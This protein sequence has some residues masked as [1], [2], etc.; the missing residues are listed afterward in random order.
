MLN[1]LIV[2]PDP[3]IALDLTEAVRAADSRASVETVE[4][5]GDCSALYGSGRRYTHGFVRTLSTHEREAAQGCI[6]LLA[7]A[8]AEVVL[9]GAELPERRVASAGSVRCLPFPFTARQVAAI[10]KPMPEAPTAA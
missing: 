4:T 2:E 7:R 3:V 10:L 6:D 8:G 5:A 1:V 9:L